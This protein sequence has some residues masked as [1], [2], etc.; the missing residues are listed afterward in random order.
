MQHRSFSAYLR[1]L[2][3]DELLALRR[4]AAAEIANRRAHGSREQENLRRQWEDLAK[5]AGLTK[6]EWTT[7]LGPAKPD[8]VPTADRTDST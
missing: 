3:D 5:R 2:S 8:A 7:L 1:S 4:R 6:E